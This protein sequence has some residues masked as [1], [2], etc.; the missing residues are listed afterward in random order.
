VLLAAGRGKR[1][2][3]HTDTTPK[4]LLPVAG[5]PTLDLYAV[6]LG[7]AGV[8]A[9]VFVT[10]HL[11]EQIADYANHL[12]ARFGL[13][14]G[15]VHQ[16]QLDGTAAALQA[17][18]H[19]SDAVARHVTQSSF[20]LIAT[21]YLLPS[22]F[23]AD[24]LRFHASHE[25]TVSISLKRIPSAQ[26]AARSSVRFGANGMITEVVEKPPEGSAP[27][28]LSANLAYVLPTE[29]FHY[30]SSVEASVRGERELQSALNAYLSAGGTARGIEQIAPQEWSPELS[31]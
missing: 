31:R 21:D 28:D 13:R 24:L 12:P 19:S 3:P 2:R 11:A 7:V 27:S 5:K 15:T 1:L 17:V 10:H 23:I 26:M 4:P 6:A 8:S 9:V 14:A 18:M 22:Q 30:L 29:I 16:P 25:A 20:L